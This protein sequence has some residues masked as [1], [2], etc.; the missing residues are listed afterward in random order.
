VFEKLVREAGLDHAVSADSAGTIDS[1][2]GDAPDR[3]AIRAAA[4]RGIDIAHQ[5]ARKTRPEDFLDFDLIVAMD[6]G[7]RRTLSHMAGSAGREKI[8]LLL[9]FAP[10]AGAATGSNVPDPYY[11]D[12]DGFERV[13]DLSH[14][15]ASGL[16]D[17][18]LTHYRLSPR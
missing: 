18:L 4:A 5:R 15:S 16:I 12:A 14:A 2:A 11:G 13:L 7:N 1:H 3:R 8:R 9:D 10:D 17:H 6:D